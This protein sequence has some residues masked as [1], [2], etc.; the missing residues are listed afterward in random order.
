MGREKSNHSLKKECKIRINSLEAFELSC[1]CK[2]PNNLIFH[3]LLCRLR[4]L[5]YFF[6]VLLAI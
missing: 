4:N 1:R 5:D 2:A 6:Y 3:V